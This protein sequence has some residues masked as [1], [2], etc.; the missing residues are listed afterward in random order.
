VG[1]LDSFSPA[2]LSYRR[3]RRGKKALVLATYSP[4]PGFDSFMPFSS[5]DTPETR[6][7]RKVIRTGLNKVHAPPGTLSA[8]RKKPHQTR[9]S[10][11]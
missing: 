1:S 3:G 9:A 10:P 6:T 5:S 11:K 4:Y 7:S 2:F 8:I